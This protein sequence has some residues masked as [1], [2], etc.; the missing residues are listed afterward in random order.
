MAKAISAFANT[1]GGWL[2]L[3]VDQLAPDNQVAAS[4]PGIPENQLDT[5]QQR[6]QSVTEH[7]NP[8]PHY[9]TKIFR[10]PCSKIE[11]QE[12]KAI[13][14]IE[15]PQSHTA[16]HIHKDGRIYRRVGDSSEPKPETDGLSWINSGDG[17]NLFQ[18]LDPEFSEAEAKMPYMR[19]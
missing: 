1:Y 12:G 2:F 16:P 5:I 6:R 14:A 17:L 11:L 4:F 13:I 19:R 8:T 7:L 9:E 10:G 3:G 15:I 18:N